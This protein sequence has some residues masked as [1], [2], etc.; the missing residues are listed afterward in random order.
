M[1]SPGPYSKSFIQWPFGH[2]EATGLL[3]ARDRILAGNMETLVFDSYSDF[4]DHALVTIRKDQASGLK[5]IIAVHNENRGPAIGGCR[6]LPYRSMEDAVRDVLRLSRGMTYKTAIA[7]ILYGGG[8]AVIIADPQRDKSELLLEA[9]GDFVESLAGRYITSFDSGTTLDDIRVIARRTKHAAGFLPEAGNASGSTA[10]GVYHCML[11]A[12]EKVNGSA[13]LAG[14]K[15]AI[16]GVGN[17]GERLAKLLARDGVQL[18]LADTDP[19][20][21]EALASAIGAKVVNSDAILQE[22]CDILSPC[23]LGGILSSET[24]PKLGARAV[25]GGANNQLA[26]PEDDVRLADRGI[27]YCPD[28]LAN[29]GG[30]IDLHYQR[31]HWDLAA[32]ERHVASLGETFRQVIERAEKER[33]PTAEIADRIAEERFGRNLR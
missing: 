33:R 6:I 20:R 2:P 23:A 13:T 1:A 3:P 32:V 22:P 7:D 24:I 25:V 31:S 29:A 30:I 17:V 9:M 12:A 26:R 18:I 8:K 27:L 11:A 28:Y 10:L 16:Q 19:A 21:A 15:V 4:A 5:A 14:L